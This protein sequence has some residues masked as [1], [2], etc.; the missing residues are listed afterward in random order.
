MDIGAPV[1]VIE[2][3]PVTEPV[4]VEAPVTEPVEPTKEPVGA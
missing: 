3:E 2:I 4:P 1:E